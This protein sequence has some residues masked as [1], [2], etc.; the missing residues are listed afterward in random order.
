MLIQNATAATVVPWA[1][2]SSTCGFY[3]PLH[4]GRCTGTAGMSSARQT[5]DWIRSLAIEMYETI[6]QGDLASLMELMPED[7]SLP[8]IV[9]TAPGEWFEGRTAALEALQVQARDYPDLRLEAGDL[10]CEE[11]GDTGWVAD[12]PSLILPDGR[13][14]P[15]RTTSVFSREAGTWRL[16]CSHLSIGVS[17]E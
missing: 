10:R 5:R 12:R 15:T 7:E 3:Q 1:M 4:P 13:R 17:D 16:A 11:N 6:N 2:S 14:V 9:G 8:V